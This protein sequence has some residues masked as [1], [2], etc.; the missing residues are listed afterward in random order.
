MCLRMASIARGEVLFPFARAVAMAAAASEEAV[1]W[2]ELRSTGRDVDMALWI[3]R[4]RYSATKS[5]C[6]SPQ[7]SHLTVGSF[8]GCPSAEVK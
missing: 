7:N 1:L 4:W 6:S 3:L 8:C 2:G 5:T